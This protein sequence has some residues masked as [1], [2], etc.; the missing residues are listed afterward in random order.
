MAALSGINYSIGIIIGHVFLK[1][2]GQPYPITRDR[3]YGGQVKTAWKGAMRRAGI[4]GFT[5]HDCRHTW[6]SWHYC[7]HRNLLLLLYEGGW[8]SLDL[9]QRYAHVIGSEHVGAIR[10]FRGDQNGD[11]PT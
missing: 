10:L 8:S 7:L 1:P 9:V 2:D 11:Q 6:A 5:V 3:G 4:A